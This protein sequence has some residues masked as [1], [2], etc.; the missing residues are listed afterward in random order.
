M[1]LDIEQLQNATVLDQDGDKIGSVGQIYL[2]DQTNEPTFATV[3]TGLFGNKESFVPL[4][5]ATESG[6]DLKVPYTKD[7]V[8]DAPKVDADGHLTEQEQDEIYRYYK[9]D[10]GAASGTAGEGRTDATDGYAGGAAG[11]P[12]S[13][14]DNTDGYAGGAAGRPDDGKDATDGYAG[15]APAAAETDRNTADG[16]AGGAVDDDNAVTLREEQLNVGKQ[17][18]ETGRVRI[19]KYVVTEQQTVTVPVEREEF[20]VVREPITD[21]TTGGTLGEETAEVTL[22]EEQPVVETQV[23]DKER[24][25]LQTHTVSDEKQVQAEVGHEEF[26]VDRDG[27]GTTDAPKQ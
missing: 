16:Y 6:S 19:R 21:G 13:G 4:N 18:V 11:Q 14:V 7:Y 22:S 2:D 17:R 8:H 12:A 27:D 23:V 9:L 25:G 5:Q 26:A 20:E 1:T 15:G 10:G 3:K 24:V